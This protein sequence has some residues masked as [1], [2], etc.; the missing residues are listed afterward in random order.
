MKTKAICLLALG[1]L[2]GFALAGWERTYGDIGNDAATSVV[3]GNDGGY[4]VAGYRTEGYWDVDTTIFGSDTLYDSTYVSETK[5]FA[6]KIDESGDSVWA[7]LYDTEYF[8]FDILPKIVRISSGGYA[9]LFY[10]HYIEGIF[11]RTDNLG[12]ELWRS[13]LSRYIRNFAPTTDGGFIFTGNTIGYPHNMLLEKK[14]SLL[15]PEWSEQY[16]GSETEEGHSVAQTSDGGYIIGGM[17]ETW[18]SFYQNTWVVRTDPLGVA[19]WA[20]VYGR[21]GAKSII[22]TDDGG[23]AFIEPYQTLHRIDN[24]GDTI[25]TR[26][27]VPLHECIESVDGNLVVVG[28]NGGDLFLSEINDDGDTIWT[29]SYGGSDTDNGYSVRQTSEGGYIVAGYTT[30][31]GAGGYDIYL[32]KTD[33]L[34]N[35]GIEENPPFAKPE[36]FSLSAYPNPFNSAVTIAAPAGAGVCDTPLRVEIY[37]VN[38][39]RVATVTEL[40][41]VPVGEHLRVLPNDDET[42]NGRAHR[43]SPT[44]NVAIWRPDESLPSGVYLVRATVGG[45]GDLNPTGKTATKRI[46]YLK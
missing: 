6:M 28:N 26:P 37:D 42:E 23:F 45:R 9:L 20:K 33:S 44:H 21:Y 46:V 38:G 4:V 34:G 22:E 27:L 8:S 18:G 11:I 5:P 31:L 10:P 29:R 30:S 43:P 2:A 13:S 17:T 14:D 25:W 3:L 36:A 41:E 35:T 15:N 16:G 12:N 19:L 39:R 24:S 32:I 7:H 40:V 1:L